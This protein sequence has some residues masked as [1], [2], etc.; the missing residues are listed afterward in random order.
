MFDLIIKNPDDSIYWQEHFNSRADA[1]SWLESEQS[2]PYW[3]KEYIVSIVERPIPS[4][5]QSDIEA[6]NQR[7]SSIAILKSE[8]KSLAAQSE[9][10][11]LNIK[12]VV[13]KS[14]QLQVL[15]K[16]LD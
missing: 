2:R 8:L 6:E 9:L 14:L 16:G 7:Q 3:K 12:D 5:D 15:M 13:K 10:T 1:E 4:P 11:D